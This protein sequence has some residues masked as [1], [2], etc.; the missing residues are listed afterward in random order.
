MLRVSDSRPDALRLRFD[1]LRPALETHVALVIA[2]IAGPRPTSV[3]LI[4]T[5][6]Q[7]VCH[8]SSTALTYAAAV[9]ELDG[10]VHNWI[11]RRHIV[12]GGLD[13]AFAYLLPHLRKWA[14]QLSQGLPA[15]RP[16]PDDFVNDA[17][18]K[19]RAAPAFCSADNPIGYAFRVVKNLVVDHARRASRAAEI[20]TQPSRGVGVEPDASPERLFAVVRRARL[21]AKERCM[22][23]RKVF[24]GMSV[25]AAQ[26]ACGGPP[27]AP[28]YVLEKIYDKLAAAFGVERGRS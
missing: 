13:H 27:G 6:W 12:A 18:L 17:F 14:T 19:L 5:T 20:A 21:S 9:R 3:E 24:E 2:D 15:P 25:T 22:V 10:A 23:F 16:D 26:K 8:R 1:E 7:A 11:L 4:E 28:Y